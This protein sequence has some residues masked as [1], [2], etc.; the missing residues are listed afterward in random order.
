MRVALSLLALVQGEWPSCQ[1]EGAVLRGRGEYAVFTDVT[2][3][4]GTAGCFIDNCEVSDKFFCDSPAQCGAT[5]SKVPECNFW[6]YGVEDGGHKCWL[7]NSDAGKEE[8][9]DF[10]FGTRSCHPPEWPACIEQDTVLRGAGQYG[11]FV[12]AAAKGKHLGCFNND[13]TKTDK[14]SCSSMDEC[15]VICSQSEG[16]THWTFGN[17]GGDTKCWLRTGDGG[18]EAAPGFSS[19]TVNCMPLEGFGAGM[20]PLPSKPLAEAPGNTACWGGGY[21]FD[22][23]CAD[24]FGDAGN[25]R[26]WDG[27]S[28]S[29]ENCCIPP[30][31]QEL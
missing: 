26:C 20:P 1:G 3:H 11:L 6:T 19:A 13:C 21:T 4:G 22:L 12:D 24:S 10:V 16:C 31:R 28:F 14:F 9:N 7:R 15:A 29:F 27:Q 30:G 2:L 23:C 18:R 25:P 5:C 8:Q 17:E